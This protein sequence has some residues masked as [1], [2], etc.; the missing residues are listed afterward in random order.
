MSGAVF[1][2]RILG[3]VREQVF[4]FFFGAGMATD[5]YLVA[6]RIPNLLRDLFAE[7]AL[8]SAFVTVFSRETDPARRRQ[9]A[10]RVLVALCL[11]VGS[12]CLAIFLFS[13][14]LVE[15][16]APDFA[17][18]PGKIELTT[19]LT[20]WFAPF[21]LFVAAAALS[22]GVLNTLG[23]F[24]VPSLGAAAFNLASIFIG[25]IAAFLLRAHGFEA[26]IVGFTVGS[27]VG[28]LCQW[29]VQWP[30]LAKE[31]YSPLQ[32]VRESS[33]A[34]AL[35]KS[36][37]DPAL[38]KIAWLMAPS[39]L[40]VAA[41]QINVF[42]NTI[43]ASG[44][45]EGSVSWMNYAYRLLH[46]PL[47]VFGVA[48]STAALPSLAR[49]M[50][51]GKLE[52]FESTLCRAL[53]LTLIL[54]IGSAAGLI[55]FRMP[56]VSLLFEHGRFSEADTLQTAMALTAFSLALPALN[57]TK[58]CVQVYH[59]IDKVWIPSTVS[60]VL[61]VSHYFVASW[62]AARFGH[63]GL[64]LATAITSLTNMFVLSLILKVRGHRLADFE[65][66]KTLLGCLVGVLMLLGLELCGFSKWLVGLREIS[67]L[68]FAGATLVSIAFFGGFYLFLAAIP[69]RES[70]QWFQRLT[71]RLSGR[72]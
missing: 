32:A 45:A 43:L 58:I 34:D 1:L 61:V 33:S 21:L 51:D 71:R 47:G 18:V 17:S 64:A 2:S 67:K 41:V 70:R 42:V 20:R 37:K 49:L 54:G 29:L 57:T 10:A 16:M 36:L 30:L 7:G 12:I 23:H 31:G 50:H 13:G 39:I 65:T 60:L 63:V 19:T 46:F 5:A 56:L 22:M 9:M 4:A 3:L 38:K 53:R 27:L 66:L 44:L 11:I 59:A 52:E 15:W 35:K 69:S 40:A 72:K 48:L 14:Q 6:F 8:S 26:M 28:G 25:G 24:F 55:A 62:G 68:A